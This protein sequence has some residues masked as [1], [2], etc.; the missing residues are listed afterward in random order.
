MNRSVLNCNLFLY[1]GFICLYS[2]FDYPSVYV[3]FVV[4]V[5]VFLFYLS[6]NS[7]NSDRSDS[8]ETS[9]T[10]TN[11][12]WKVHGESRRWWSDNC[13]LWFYD[14]FFANSNH[15]KKLAKVLGEMKQKVLWKL[16][17]KYHVYLEATKQK[18]KK[19]LQKYYLQSI[20]LWKGIQDSLGY[21]IPRRGFRISGAGLSQ[22]KSLSV[23]LVFWSLIVGGFRFR[24]AVFRMTWPRIPDSTSKSFPDSGFHW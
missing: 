9:Q 14:V 2:T 21:W 12:P 11:R 8:A 16:K 1:F 15:K 19:R 17:G 24:L 23:E 22:C 20:A 7:D 3:F 18:R 10:S 4:S 13:F 6:N 5:S